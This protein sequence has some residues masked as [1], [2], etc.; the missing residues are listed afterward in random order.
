MF[1][2]SGQNATAAAKIYI[3][4]DVYDRLVAL[5]KKTVANIVVS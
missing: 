1:Y 4:D 3:H 2:N 5:I